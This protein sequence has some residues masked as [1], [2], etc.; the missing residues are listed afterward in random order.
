MFLRGRSG[1]LVLVCGAALMVQ[2]SVGAQEDGGRVRACVHNGN[3]D[4]RI[5]GPGESCRNNERAV[6]WSI[7]GPQ[8]VAGEVGAPGLQGMQGPQGVAGPQGLTGLEGPQGATGPEGPAG[9]DCSG[10]A[11]G[12][13]PQPCGFL[14][15]DGDGFDP[16]KGIPILTVSGGVM[17]EAGQGGGGSGGTAGHPVLGALKVRRLTNEASPLL[18][19]VAATGQVLKTVR[20]EFPRPDGSVALRYRLSAAEILDLQSGEGEDGRGESLSFDYGEISFSYTP[21]DDDGGTSG[22]VSFC[23]NKKANKEC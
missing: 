18:F 1:K 9:K 11:P 22:E 10:P 21:Q 8:G 16:T 13:G 5:V 20:L 17:R 3:G 15:V 23:W 19:G 2:G 7:R 14:Y 6:S 12:P 4:V